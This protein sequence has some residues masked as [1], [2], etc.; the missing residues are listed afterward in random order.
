M[1]GYDVRNLTAPGGEAL[2]PQLEMIRGNDPVPTTP[3]PN[4]GYVLRQAIPEDRH[5]YT[6]TFQT[7]FEEPS[8]FADLTQKSLPNGF[9]V[10]VQVHQA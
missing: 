6:Q 1:S 2:K 9:F 4:T 5:S 8:P 3:N 7:A 10:V